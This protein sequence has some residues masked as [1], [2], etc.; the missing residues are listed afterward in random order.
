MY[1][2]HDV[3]ETPQRVTTAET[4][5]PQKN[6]VTT[7]P[8]FKENA[9]KLENFFNSNEAKYRLL[10]L[11]N[12]QYYAEKRAEKRAKKFATHQ[13]F[14]DPHENFPKGVGNFSH[15]FS[16]SHSSSSP[17]QSFSKPNRPTILTRSPGNSFCNREQTEVDI[18]AF[19][20]SRKRDY[21][22]KEMKSG[23]PR[24]R[25]PGESQTQLMVNN[26]SFDG[27]A[28]K[29]WNYRNWQAKSFDIS[30][31]NYGPGNVGM[32][33][34]RPPNLSRT[35]WNSLGGSYVSDIPPYGTSF[36]PRF[37][38]NNHFSASFNGSTH[39]YDSSPTSP[40]LDPQSVSRSP[41]LN[42][43]TNDLN[44]ENDSPLAETFTKSLLDFQGSSPSSSESSVTWPNVT[45]SGLIPSIHTLQSETAPTSP[46]PRLLPVP[47]IKPYKLCDK[48]NAHTGEILHI[49]LTPPEDEVTSPASFFTNPQPYR[50]IH[51]LQVPPILPASRKPD[52]D[53]KP[54]ART[55]L[56]QCL[57]KV[58][59]ATNVLEK[60]SIQLENDQAEA[61]EKPS[62]PSM[63]R[64]QS[65]SQSDYHLVSNERQQNNETATVVENNG[66]KQQNRRRGM[67]RRS[68]SIDPSESDSEVRSN[69][70][71]EP[72]PNS[73]RRSQSMTRPETLPIRAPM[74][75]SNSE[76]EPDSPPH[77][78]PAW[79][80]SNVLEKLAIQL[81]N[82][83]AEA[84]EKLLARSQHMK[85]HL[86]QLLGNVQ[87]EQ[88]NED[89]QSGNISATVT[90]SD[91][92]QDKS[93][94]FEQ[95]VQVKARPVSK[96]KPS[97][98]MVER[99]NEN[100][101]QL[102]AKSILKSSTSPVQPK[103]QN[104]DPDP[105]LKKVSSRPPLL[106][107]KKFVEDEPDRKDYDD[108]E[109]SE[110]NNL[111]TRVTFNNRILMIEHSSYSSSESYKSSEGDTLTEG[112]GDV[113]EKMPVMEKKEE[114]KVIAG[115]V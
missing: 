70:L 63:R 94:Q 24:V 65:I 45:H 93:V 77:I 90:V 88:M 101:R 57:R 36:K 64:S 106:R 92:G 46:R 54:V 15:S 20:D 33:P 5:S 53:E 52:N 23:V 43:S 80:L 3:S 55:R 91:T 41:N 111:N 58:G 99:N 113:L 103:P 110:E 35:N 49:T 87:N 38:T 4:P 19:E 107:Q 8:I 26:S 109:N 96:V 75:R 13:S 37:P 95:E 68:E 12:K 82:D 78:K 98:T 29:Q 74:L 28:I 18:K 79:G 67:L 105:P 7:S 115:V 66:N 9:S 114:K 102:T 104:K 108:R 48:D 50:S 85:S 25:G 71:N 17:T 30:D 44:M 42:G 72:S 1:V 39:D 32:R 27:E 89:I 76:P 62:R 61:A 73:L 22:M 83:Q 56:V 6:D 40:F 11:Q 21:E 16:N 31:I 84:A 51:Q 100:N 2:P 60:L 81:E 112:E 69:S 10:I 59:N 97:R 14:S 86:T 34:T 47:V